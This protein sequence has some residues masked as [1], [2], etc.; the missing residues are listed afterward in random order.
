MMISTLHNVSDISSAAA[1]NRRVHWHKVQYVE[2]LV[3]SAI[4]GLYDTDV[5]VILKE[6]TALYDAVCWHIDRL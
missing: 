5:D 6:A 2:A 1:K 4:S 3:D